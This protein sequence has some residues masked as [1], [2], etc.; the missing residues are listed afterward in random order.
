MAYTTVDDP[1]AYFNTLLYTGNGSS[2]D[3]SGLDFSPDWVWMK[4]RSNAA[5]HMVYDTVRGVKKHF[6]TNTSDVEV[7]EADDDIGLNSF[8]S[9]GFTVKVN[10]NTNTNT[11]TYAAWNWKAGTA[12]SNDASA[13]GI[14]SIDSAGS[15]NTTAGFSI[16]T[17]TGT[18]GNETVKHGLSTTLDMLL[19]KN[20]DSAKDWRM[21]FKGFSGTERLELN[22]T[23][24]KATTNT[25]WNGTIPGS[26]VF[27]LGGDNNTNNNTDPYVAYCFHSVKG[28]SKFGTYSGSNSTSGPFIHTGF[29]PA[30]IMVKRIDSEDTATNM[31]GSHW[32]I[33][34]NKRDPINDSG[35]AAALTANRSDAEDTSNLTHVEFVSNGFKFR[36]GADA[37]NDT[38]TYIY[39]SFAASPFVTSKG[40]PTTAR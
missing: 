20:R 35:T 24:A 26:S 11:H 16:V 31:N 9:D 6:H 22:N 17:Y 37:V 1:T 29:K 32:V 28:Y 39:M 27:N 13:T 4:K 7:S 34:D 15:V 18:G 10:G 8:N 19:V 5:N 2:L 38:G 23:E 40:V 12:F 3:V 14:G 36:G 33:I 21:W 25:S 30:W